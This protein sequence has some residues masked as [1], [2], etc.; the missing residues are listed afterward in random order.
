MSDGTTARARLRSCERSSVRRGIGRAPGRAWMASVIQAEPDSY[1]RLLL[2][3]GSAR[4]PWRDE[5][6]ALHGGS[7]KVRKATAAATRYGC[8]R[9]EFFGG[10]ET[11]GGDAL[12]RAGGLRIDPAEQA[13]KR[14]EP[15]DWQRDATSPQAT[16][17]ASRRGG[18]K[19][20]GRNMICRW[21]WQ[22]EGSPRVAGSG[23]T[24]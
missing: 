21:Q 2:A 18:A 16:F 5:H 12:L 13:L 23:R 22:T 14:S 20:R 9:G 17:G 24:L 4:A 15:Q 1:R 19:P 6:A 3:G 11:R 7:G 8:W 10:Y